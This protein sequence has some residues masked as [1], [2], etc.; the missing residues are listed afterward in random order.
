MPFF[1]FS[2]TVIHGNHA[3]RTLGYPT[4]N[5]DPS[6]GSA[7]TIPSGVYAVLVKTDG[8][9]YSGMASAGTRPTI[10]D[11]RFSIEVHLFGYNGDLYGQTITI[12]FI[13][14]M[15]EV[16][17]FGS[18][19]ELT[20]QLQQDEILAKRILSGFGKPDSDTP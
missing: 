20:R 8:S 18:L 3:G 10:D 12:E 11:N 4:A 6:T 17:R 16:V 2:G 1:S 19:T 5:L 9:V 7:C 13:K 14:K 15:R